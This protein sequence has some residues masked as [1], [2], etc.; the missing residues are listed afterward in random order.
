MNIFYLDKDPKTCAQYHHNIH[1]SKMT[2]ETAQ[3]LSTAHRFFFGDL[4]DNV[5]KKYGENH[6]CNIWVRESTENYLWVYELFVALAEEY[7]Y[8]FDKN[9]LSY[10]KLKDILREPPVNNKVP[11][12]EPPCVMDEKYIIQGDAISSYRNY[13]RN[14]KSGKYTKRNSPDW[15]RG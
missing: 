1:V 9:H 8:R 3:I 5:Y 7:N 12:F 4:A 10:V 13:Y 6:P 15:L 2:L 14:E 11:F